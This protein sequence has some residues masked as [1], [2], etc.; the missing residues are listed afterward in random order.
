MEKHTM[1]N[2]ERKPTLEI[3]LSS[4]FVFQKQNTCHYL[5]Y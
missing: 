5:F 2:K 3:V 4:V 1:D